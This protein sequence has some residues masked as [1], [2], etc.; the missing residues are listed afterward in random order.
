[1]SQQVHHIH[2]DK[3]AWCGGE[4]IPIEECA[5]KFNDGPHEFSGDCSRCPNRAGVDMGDK[6][7]DVIVVGAGCVGSAVAREL[8]KYKLDVL[9][10]DKADDVTQGPT[11]GNSGIV[12]AGYD[13][14]PGSV[15]AKYCWKGNQMF[16]Q[17]DKELHFGYHKNGSLVVARS[18]EDEEMLQELLARGK[19]NGVK[20]LRIVKQ[21]ELREMEPNIAPDCTSALYSPDAGTVTPYEY[22]IALAENAADNGVEF[23]VN[24]EVVGITVKD[25]PSASESRFTLSLNKH[26]P[27]ALP[28]NAAVGAVL[29]AAACAMATALSSAMEVFSP[30]GLLGLFVLS[31]AAVIAVF[32]ASGISS[33]AVTKETVRAKYVVNSAGLGSDKVAKLVG[34]DDF[35]IK[36]RMGEYLLF[37]KNQGH[38]AKHI[39]FP[40]PGKYGKGVLVQ[41]TLWGNLI[42]G[43]TAR[44]CHNP[45]HMAMTAKDIMVNIITKCRELV[46]G[47]DCSQII[48]SFAGA[49]A[50]S[51]RGDW[52]IEQSTVAGFVM[53]AGVDSPGLA[54]SPAIAMEVV[55]LLQ[56]GGLQLEQDPLF[57]PYRRP[58]IVP[59]AGWRG[60]KLEHEDPKKNVVCKCEKVT[61]A[62]IVDAINR[63]LKVDSTQA[64]RK[65][66]RAGMGHCQGEY[67]EPRVAKLIAREKRMAAGSVGRRPWPASSLLPQ[68]WLTD[69]QKSDLKNLA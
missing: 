24:R 43:P 47:F 3:G 27:A 51:T 35:E 40:A 1:M 38:L 11:K 29:A 34:I 32:F 14:K 18:A 9:V 49:R 12:H 7:Y 6:E 61:E 60:I 64:V 4:W 54:G 45:E 41:P 8:S 46:P 10:L 44:D 16:S 56:K 42:L 28:F 31:C 20:R 13:D 5:A 65:R 15:R 59:K 33:P 69:K 17:L 55:Q 19:K 23:R 58:I 36:P 26:S 63:S 67:C 37:N 62:E 52:I 50:K 22:A 21:K 68:R 66:S 30:L 39:L 53:A 57:N 2:G 48:H 25:Q